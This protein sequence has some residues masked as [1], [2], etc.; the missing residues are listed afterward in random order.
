MKK[1]F[2][3]KKLLLGFL[4]MV[5]ILAIIVVS[6]F[7]PFIL[8]LS[9]VGTTEFITDQMIIMAITISVTISMMFIAQVSNAQNPNSELAKA[10]VEFM[11]SIKKIVNHT[12]FYQ[13]IKRVLQVNDRRDIAE[14]GMMKLGVPFA[15]YELSDTEI[16][17]LEKPQKFGDTFYKSLTKK[18]IEGVLSLKKQVAR[19]KFVSPNYYTS[20]KSLMID[21]NLSEI[22]RGENK[23][24]IFTV[25]FQ[26]ALK[27]VMSFIFAAILASLV[28][29]LAQEDG[30][31]AQTWMRFLSRTFAFITSSFLGFTL[32]CKLNDLDAFY[33]T[34]RVEAHTLYLEDK[35]FKPIDEA[36]QEFIE[37]VLN[38]EHAL[39]GK[40]AHLIEHE[41][42]E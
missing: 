21:K 37:R 2:D 10:K 19:I 30:S 33:I 35:D 13:W 29:D 12:W 15:V 23:K 17:S 34:K 36:K 6:S 16:R 8:D 3:N 25:I 7:W 32:G 22:A 18:Q 31:T 20:F 38:E 28:R 40:D 39:I 1:V 26:L 4:T 41:G 9:R 42:D 27:I 5:V 24:K 14:K 11:N